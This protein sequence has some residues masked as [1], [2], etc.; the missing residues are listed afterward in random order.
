M[1]HAELL[2]MLSKGSSPQAVLRHLPKIFDNVHGLSFR[3]DASSAPT[4]VATGMY[5]WGLVLCVLAVCVY[6]RA[7]FLGRG[8]LVCA[9]ACFVGRDGAC[10]IAPH[11]VVFEGKTSMRRAPLYAPF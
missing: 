3:S 4:K 5:R 1:S 2:D 8:A 10:R 9:R 7:F 11:V 6:M